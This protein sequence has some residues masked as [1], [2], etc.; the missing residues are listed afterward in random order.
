MA[1]V[2]RGDWGKVGKPAFKII[3]IEESC[4]PEHS[5]PV[6]CQRR[7]ELHLKIEPLYMHT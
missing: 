3:G 4:L 6:L 7:A 2:T 5:Q 1:E